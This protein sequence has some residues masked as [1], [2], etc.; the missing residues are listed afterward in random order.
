VLAAL[1]AVFASF[2]RSGSRSNRQ[3][4]ARLTSTG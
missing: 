4:D 1:M 2:T 3:R